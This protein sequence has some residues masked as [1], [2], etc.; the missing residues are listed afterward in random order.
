MFSGFNIFQGGVGGVLENSKR[1]E[2]EL[3]IGG[4]PADTPI[5]SMSLTFQRK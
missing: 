1:E 2:I 4:I 3:F 5:S